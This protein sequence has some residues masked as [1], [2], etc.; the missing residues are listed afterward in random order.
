LRCLLRTAEFRFQVRAPVDTF[1]RKFGVKLEW[2]PAHPWPHLGLDFPELGKRLAQTASSD[3]APWTDDVRDHIDRHQRRVVR[4]IR[5]GHGSHYAAA[6]RRRVIM[7]AP[8]RA[9]LRA[10]VIQRFD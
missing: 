4:S 5:I 3:V 9:S 8:M 7:A 10:F 2:V 1:R 6:A